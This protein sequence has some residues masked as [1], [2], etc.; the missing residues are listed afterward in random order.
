M[1]ISI[2]FILLLPFCKVRSQNNDRKTTIAPF[3][4]QLLNGDSLFS[5]DLKKNVPVMLIYFSPTCEHC[6]EFTRNLLQKITAFN[7]AQ[8]LFISYLPLN[9]VEK[10]KNDFDL[11]KYPNIK[12]GTEG[13]T[14]IVQRFYNIRNF[15]FIALYDKKGSLFAYY[16]T[17]P[18]IDVLIKQ[19]ETNK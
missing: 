3:H 6:Q 10:F 17:A 8:I 1:K 5:Q 11:D 7:N 16:R 4:I 15:P 14:F 19:F 2:V 18:T 12:I 9:D 13:Y